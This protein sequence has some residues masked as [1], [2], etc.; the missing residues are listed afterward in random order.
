MRFVAVSVLLLVTKPLVR[1]TYY[2]LRSHSTLSTVDRMAWKRAHILVLTVVLTLG[3]SGGLVLSPSVGAANVP[4][5]APSAPNSLAVIP[6]NTALVV[7]WTAPTWTGG[8]PIS[9]Y[10]VNVVPGHESCTTVS[11]GCT[12]TGLSNGTQY[13]VRV[14]AVNSVHAGGVARAKAIPSTT[15]NCSYLGYGRICRVVISP[16]PT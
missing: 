16:L 9:S 4:A 7:S 1:T 10:V 6:V 8:A 12:V 5:K 13:A 2:P 3:L 11:L 15:Q 14:Q